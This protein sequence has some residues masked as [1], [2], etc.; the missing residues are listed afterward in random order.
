MLDKRSPLRGASTKED[1]TPTVDFYPED[2]LIDMNGKKM[3]WQGV[4]LLS[5][6]D[7]DMLLNAMAKPFDFL[8]PD[9]RPAL[10]IPSDLPPPGANDPPYTIYLSEEERRRNKWGS[11]V[12]FAC[13]EHPLYPFYEQLYAKRKS[14]DASVICLFSI[15]FGA[16]S[17]PACASRHQAQFRDKRHCLS[18][19][20]LY[21]RLD[22][23]FRFVNDARHS[24]R[25]IA[26]GALFLP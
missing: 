11:N 12:M 15:N 23:L 10:D 7:Q 24:E 19:P 6:I 26:F 3:A 14:Q 25:Q 9:E 21:S 8:P 5:F 2:F 4:A 20:Y 18:R 17:T 13:D 16:D 22:I 1:G